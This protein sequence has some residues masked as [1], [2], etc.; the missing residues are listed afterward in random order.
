MS[1]AR[2]RVLLA[3]IIG[4]AAGIATTL[5]D[6][7]YLAPLVVW[8]VAALVF[9]IWTWLII[10]PMDGE[11]TAS[12][13]LSEDPTQPVSDLVLVGASLASLGAVV[14]V[15]SKAG[16]TGHLDQALSAAIAVVSVILSW[17]V[18]HTV[19]TVRYAVNYYGHP[20]GGVDFAGTDTPAYADF[21]YLAFTVGMTFQVSDMGFKNTRFRKIALRHS[22]LSYL[23]GTVVVATVINLVVG[24]AR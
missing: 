11:E 15:L 8:D 12:H 14:L 23:F 2:T 22:L 4:L 9:V 17:I 13:A 16:D 19:F 6:K 1:S 24:L 21:A 20:R 5:T 10:W 18:L 3:A 7:A